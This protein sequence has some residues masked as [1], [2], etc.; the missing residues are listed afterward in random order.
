MQRE[1]LPFNYE[2]ALFR[3]LQNLRQGNKSV[4]EYTDEFYQ[5]VSRNNLSD[6]KSQ[7]VARYIGGLHQSIQDVLTLHVNFL[8]S[9]ACERAFAIEK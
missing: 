2:E 7:L 3:Q 8:V 5:V 1:F 9:E 6:S 4:G